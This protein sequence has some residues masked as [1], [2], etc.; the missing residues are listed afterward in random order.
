MKMIYGLLQKDSLVNKI[1][2]ISPSQTTSDKNTMYQLK[3]E[4]TSPEQFKKKSPRY[5]ND[6]TTAQL[7]AVA[8]VMPKWVFQARPHF[9]MHYKPEWVAMFEPTW[10]ADNDTKYMLTH[11][12]EWMIYNKPSIVCRFDMSIVIDKNPNWCVNN[13]PEVLAYVAPALLEKYDR[14]VLKQY[15]PEEHVES[16]SFFKR[17]KNLFAKYWHYGTSKA[18]AMHDPVLSRE[19]IDILK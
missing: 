13:I 3:D 14:D 10:M 2:T 11:C 19:V 4:S 6:L 8:E 17:V 16:V 7:L 5:L 1:D 12:M 9:M 18:Q 15:C